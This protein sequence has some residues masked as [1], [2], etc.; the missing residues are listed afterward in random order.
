MKRYNLLSLAGIVALVGLVSGCNDYLKESSGDLLI[1]QR[2]AEYQSLLVGEGYPNS[3]TADIQWMDLLTDDAEVSPSANPNSTQADG[4]DDV[5]LSTGKG[6]FTWAQDIEFY[7]KAAGDAYLARYRNIMACN[8]IIENANN[9]EG[10][11]AEVHACVAEAYALRALNYFYLVNW[12][13]VPYNPNTADKDPGV[14]IR[15]QSKMVK[16]QPTRSTVAEVYKLINDDLDHALALFKTAKKSNNVYLMNEKAANLLK[17]R[18][19]LYTEQWDDV[20]KYGNT[21]SEDN[22]SLY[23]I[24]GLT[25]DDLSEKNDYAFLNKTNREAVW[26]FGG[27]VHSRQDYMDNTILIK[28]AGFAPSHAKEGGLIYSYEGGDNR[29]YAFFMQDNI[30]YDAEWDWYFTYEDNRHLPY[31][32]YTYDNYS[33]ALRTSE[34]LLSVAEAYVQ[35]GQNDLAIQLLNLLR[36][37]RF[38]SETYKDLTAAEFNTTDALLQFVRDERRRELC[39]EETHRWNDLRR[40]GM[41]RIEHTYYASKNSAPEVYVLEEG[42]K[43]Y[44]LELPK[45]ELEYNQAVERINRRVISAQ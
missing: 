44:T 27:R 16:D 11:S 19:A 30:D 3:L 1:P 22:F 32:H 37:N 43:N 35:K 10:D 2:V 25:K 26:M 40:Y 42:D 34:A 24:S 12:Y 13:G 38:T 17:C 36:K 33:Q 31:K 4:D 45:A 7:D 9:M 28:G 41:P 23:N 39:F 15:L 21:L 18:V 5:Y 6:A 14:I 8:L 20:I 29:I